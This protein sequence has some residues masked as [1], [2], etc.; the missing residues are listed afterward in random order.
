MGKYNDRSRQARDEL[1]DRLYAGMAASVASTRL[2]AVEGLRWRTLPL[3]LPARNDPG[4]TV[5]ENRAKMADP[6]VNVR[7]RIRAATRV[8]YAQRADRPIDLSLLSV[9]D[10]H[11]LHLP[12]ESMVEF[13]LFAQRQKPDAFVAVAAYGDVGPG[14][15]CTEA[16]FSEGGYEPTASRVALHSETLFKA[17]IRQLLEEE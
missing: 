2:M 1:T 4:Y 15:I 6:K 5:E 10:V 14:Y 7:H 11:L 16:S 9:G 12:G 8:A 3:A 17:A 13:Q